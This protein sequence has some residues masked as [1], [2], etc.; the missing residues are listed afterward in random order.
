MKTRLRPFRPIKPGEIL[1]EELGAKEWS[2]VDL[3][4]II[5]RS[6]HEIN[7]IIAGKKTIGLALTVV[8]SKALGT[9][10]DYWFNLEAAYRLDDKCQDMC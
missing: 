5:G 7:E 3:A 4:D 2:P 9:S 6:A 8:F 1:E 10:A